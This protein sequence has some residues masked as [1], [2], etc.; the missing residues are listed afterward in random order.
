MNLRVT[1]ALLLTSLCLSASAEQTEQ[2]EQSLPS[3]NDDYVISKR[4]AG[5]KIDMIYGVVAGLTLPK[6]SDRAKSLDITNTMGFAVGLKYG[7]DLGGLEIVP[8]VWYQHDRTSIY[9]K[10]KG[11]FGDLY[12]NSI[13]VPILFSMELFKNFSVN[14]GPS[15]SLMSNSKIESDDIDD[16][17]F[18]RVKSTVGYLFGFSYTFFE[19][20]IVDLRYT[21]RFVSSDVEW[22]KGD[23][24]YDYR[25]YSFGVNIGYRF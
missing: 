17:D 21:G 13:E 12:S 14:V 2:T 1:L 15:F 24:S 23:E 7:V 4:P 3:I 5:Q 22:F 20:Y 10:D 11:Y 18:G 8:E 19:H 25:Y 6:M 9:N 16:V